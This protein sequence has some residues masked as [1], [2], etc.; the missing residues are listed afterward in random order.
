MAWTID[1][2][3]RRS[4]R[5]RWD[6]LDFSSFAS[7]PLDAAALRCLRYMHDVEYHT[8][9][10]LR[11]LLL[12]PAHLDPEITSFLSLW[13]FEEF[14]HGEALAA[15][16]AAHGEAAGADRVA[17]ARRRLGARDRIR[18]LLIGLGGYVLAED[19]VAL[20]MSWGAINEWTTQVGYARLAQLAGHPTLGALLS[21]IMRQEGR[22]I[23]FYA[24]QARRRLEAK[25]RA[26][27]RTRAALARF[28]RP[29]G[30]G[31][32]PGSETRWLMAYLLG[33]AEAKA[34]IRR[35]DRNVASL[36]GLSGLSLLEDAL[37]RLDARRPG[38]TA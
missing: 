28:W 19:F 20:Q 13:T 32:M 35:I 2:H 4:E 36:P 26:Q 22:H 30:S 21:R 12:T 15:V 29:V 9:C 31:V 6:D 11:E 33:G 3:K 23:D 34:A 10:Y 14:W 37:C 8:I 24:N 16:L 18:P 25:P 17:L 27:R 1:E 5:L 7:R 38:V